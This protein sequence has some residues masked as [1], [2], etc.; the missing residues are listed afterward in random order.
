MSVNEVLRSA[1]AP[2][3]LPCVP[4]THTPGAETYYTFSVDTVPAAWGNNA[5]DAEIC[6]VSVHL[7]APG[8]ANVLALRAQTRRLLSEA[9]F[10]WPSETDASDE[11][12]QHYL[13]ECQ[14]LQP[15]P[16]EA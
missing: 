2:T 7:W 5:P 1:L 15:V 12:G 16:R 10:T 4:D 13:Y 11:D 6:D 3:G 14:I 9:G 8:Q